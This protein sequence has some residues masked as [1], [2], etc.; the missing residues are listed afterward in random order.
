MHSI[1]LSYVLR[2]RMQNEVY[3]FLRGQMLWAR[4]ISGYYP[5]YLGLWLC[6]HKLV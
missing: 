4:D 6:I 5:A 3:E 1:T 2:Q